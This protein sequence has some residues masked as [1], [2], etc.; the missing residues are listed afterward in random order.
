MQELVDRVVVLMNFSV[1]KMV[2]EGIARASV[3]EL[4]TN[5]ERQDEIALLAGG[6][7]AEARLYAARL[8]EQ[9]AA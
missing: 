9:H 6:Q 1:K 3:S 4:L 8:L 2:D 7:F 5:K